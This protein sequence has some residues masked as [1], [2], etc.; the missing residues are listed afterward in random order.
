M[1]KKKRDKPDETNPSRETGGLA[2]TNAGL[3]LSELVATRSRTIVVVAILLAAMF[4]RAV[5]G[6]GGYSG[7]H[8]N[9]HW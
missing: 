2:D 9:R 3:V 7:T 4:M 8:E 5:V 6:L 1:A